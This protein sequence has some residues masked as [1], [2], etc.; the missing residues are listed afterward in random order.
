M[1]GTRNLAARMGRW[2]AQHRKT[3]FFGWLAFVIAAVAIGG[4][5]GTKTLE[6]GEDGVGYSQN[7]DKLIADAFP[8][9]SADESVLVQSTNGLRAGDRR[10]RAAVQDA[11]AAV[12]RERGV[13]EVGDP[14]ASDGSISED[15]RSALIR[16]EIA[17]DDDAAEVRV[18]PVLDA[19]AAVDERHP[20]LRVE[21]FGD[22]SAEKAVSEAFDDDFERAEVTSLPITLLIL[23]IAFGAL[24][25]AGIPLLLAASAVAAAIGLIG[26]VSQL[27]PVDEAIASVVL[28]IGLA[29]GVD[30]ALFYLRREREERAAGRDEE[31]ALQAAAAT[32]GRAVLISGLTVMVAMA[33]MYFAGSATF[34]GFATGTILVVAVAVVGSLTVLPATL[35]KLGDRVERGRVPVVGRLKRAGGESRLWA[36]IVDRVMRRPL[37]SLLAA[38]G[39]LVALAIPAFGMHTALPGVDTLPRD[40]EA[41]QTYDR[42]QAAFP[43]E[44]LPATVA[45]AA[46]DVTSPRLQEAIDEMRERAVASAGFHE[47]ASTEVSADRT[48]AVVDLPI[49]GDGTNA[50]SVAALESLREQII[51]ATIGRLDG[52]RAFVGGETAGTEDFNRVTNGNLPYVFAFVLG[53]AFLLLLTTFRSIVIPLKAIAL[54]LL[55]VGAAYGVL[56]LVFQD[57]HGESLLGFESN[58]AITSWLPLFLFVVLF[59]LSMDYHVFI[60]TRIKEAVDRG[61]TTEE[62]VAYGIKSTAGAVTS[63]AVVMVAVF[64]IF[65]TL[66]MLDF[67]Q[68]GVGLA[69]AVLIDATLI[70]GVLLPAAMKLLGE[71]NWWLPKWLDWLP[72]VS[73]GEPEPAHARA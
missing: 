58:G 24:V 29:V 20:E 54:N 31:A 43:G 67:K 65:G 47:P 73:H 46:D 6:D 68:M 22:A 18:G 49:A 5:V 3:A 56:K 62:A 42:I 59:G 38:G 11:I 50:E 72:R 51:P 69:S 30:Y 2:S 48:V 44:E 28:L 19:V 57:G 25:A 4:A 36:A 23:V 1:D 7:A 37:V 14:Y 34:E 8:R 45:V 10:F 35:S 12:S 61:R 71:W 21:Q 9:Q 40:I 70:R 13:Q 32:S 52:A 64:S 27:F 26:P 60:L 53:A 17:G 66:S 55:S 39:L 15:G 33:G 63:A 41:M 16:F